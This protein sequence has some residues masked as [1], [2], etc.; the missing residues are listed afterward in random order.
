[1]VQPGLR[2][3]VPPQRGS[4]GS[5]NGTRGS[6]EQE[7]L[8]SWEAQAGKAELGETVWLPEAAMGAMRWRK[9]ACPQDFPGTLR[10]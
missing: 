3:P 7:S 10:P 2:L 4:W 5:W 8:L 1:M 9:N 6:T